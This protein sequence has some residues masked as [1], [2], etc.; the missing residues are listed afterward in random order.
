M[1]TDID[2]PATEKTVSCNTTLTATA[3]TKRYANEAVLKGVNIECLSGEILLLLGPNGAGKSTLMR[4]LAGL[5]RAD[6]GAVSITAN[7]KRGSCR[8]GYAGHHSGLYSKLTLRE[9]LNLYAK[10]TRTPSDVLATTIEKWGLNSL[11]DRLVEELSRGSQSKASL[12]RAFLGDP[13]VL[14][15]D[16]PTSNLDDSAVET[17]KKEIS[18]LVTR[19]GVVMIATH[20]TARL[21]SIATRNIELFCGTIVRK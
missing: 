21:S 3:I 12:V 17:L 5:S 9:N 19:G 10:I 14:L 13:E 16:E 11:R 7:G 4:I 6:S 1:N 20:D 18:R 8:I 15:L 2:S